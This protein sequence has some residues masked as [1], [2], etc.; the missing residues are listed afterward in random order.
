MLYSHFTIEEREYLQDSLKKNLSIRQ[1]AS[2]L[3]RSPSS[4]SREIRRN[5]NTSG[6]FAQKAHTKALERRHFSTVRVLKENSKEYNFVVR[7][8]SL[9]WS[10]E[11][12]CGRWAKENPCEKKLHFSTIY[13]HI[14][15]GRFPRIKVNTHLRRR[16][17]MYRD[18]RNKFMT[19]SPNRLIRDWSDK[20]V[21]RQRIGDWE[22]DT[23]AG[24]IGSGLITTM[25]DRKSRYLCAR[26]VESKHASVQRQAIEEMLKDQPVH[27]ISLDNGVEFA[28]HEAIEKTLD[29]LVYF[30]D[31]HSPWQRGTNENINGVLRFFFPKGSD[32]SKISQ[33]D[34]D[35]AVKLL[36]SRPRKCLGWKTPEEVYHQGVALG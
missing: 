20:I 18:R 19:I 32:F 22:G 14:K 17:I 34:V 26:K 12:I 4:V 11:A 10:P 5:T 13:R 25:I 16:G 1:I 7:K 8:L 30:A 9:Y 3:G 29:T 35:R 28:E 21:R 36:N 31:P 6:Y 27:S 23:I 2:Y 15:Q 33:D 24:K